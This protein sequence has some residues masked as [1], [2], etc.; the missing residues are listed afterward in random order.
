MTDDIGG[1][2]T[3]DTDDQPPFLIEETTHTITIRVGG[4]LKEE[5]I[6]FKPPGSLQ[7]TNLVPG[8]RAEATE[9]I[10]KKKS[11]VGSDEVKR[12]VMMALS[13]L[14]LAIAFYLVPIVLS[15]VAPWEGELNPHVLTVFATVFPFLLV[16]TSLRAKSLLEK[17]SQ[18]RGYQKTVVDI[19]LPEYLSTLFD[20]NVL[21]L[22]EIHNAD[23]VRFLDQVDDQSQRKRASL[24][25]TKFIEGLNSDVVSGSR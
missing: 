19:S 13:S 24:L 10:S 1:T 15:V 12:L 3:P 6:F 16:T 11:V 2:P 22:S 9:L 23:T 17:A 18:W 21:P 20:L 14:T 4:D 25:Y 5:H 7:D 8:M